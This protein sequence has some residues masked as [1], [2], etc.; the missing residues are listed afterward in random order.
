[1][2]RTEG[3]TV[4]RLLSLVL[5]L[6][7]LAGCAPA[8]TATPPPPLDL[9]TQAAENIRTTSS[10]RMIVEQSGAPYFINTDLGAVAF[11]R[12]VAQ[13]VSPDVMQAAVR[14]LAAGLPA[15]VDVFSRGDNQ[16]YRNDIL[17][18]SRWVN[19]PFSPG[20]NPRELIVEETGFKA[21][22]Q[23]MI[24]LEYV[25]AV[26]L[27]DGSPTH[28]MKATANGP[29]VTALLAGLVYMDDVVNVDIYVHQERLL[30][31]RFIIV[32]PGTETEDQ[33]QPTTWTIDIYDFNAPPEVETP[34]AEA[35]VQSGATAEP[36]QVPSPM[37]TAEATAPI[38]EES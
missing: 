26:T 16:W 18:A 21:S 38:T 36:L 34:E 11:R 37:P 8:P 35:P 17:T 30:P 6:L 7:L 3:R 28:H 15:E 22:L 20:F 32:Q 14:L 10:F 29:D 27:E 5:I 31:V 9:L 2:N 4:P 1:M 25:G 19:A 13:Y 12:A 23:A 24:D 33:P